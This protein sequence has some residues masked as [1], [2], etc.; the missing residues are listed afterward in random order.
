MVDVPRF[1][2]VVTDEGLRGF[3]EYLFGYRWEI[4]LMFITLPYFLFAVFATSWNLYLNIEMNRWW[5]EGN[6]FLLANTII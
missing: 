4:N 6:V 1:Q 5:A 3:L 2:G